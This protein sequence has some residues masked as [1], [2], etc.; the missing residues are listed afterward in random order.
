MYIYNLESEQLQKVLAKYKYRNFNSISWSKDSKRLMFDSR[1][2]F[3]IAS[4]EFI[5]IAADSYTPFIKR[6]YNNNTYIVEMKN[7][8]YDNIV[9]LYNFDNR[10]Y[11]Q[12]ADGLYMDS[13]NT[14]I[15]YTLDYSQG[16]KIVN[17]KTLESKEIENGPI[18]C[19]NILKSTG[20]IVYT[21]TNPYFKD[22][23][24][25]LLVIINPDAMTKKV[26]PLYT[27][28]YYLSP[29]EDKIYFTSNYL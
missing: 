1:M 26:Q 20:E 4:K 13:D 28:T 9:A 18:Y 15:L 27:P 8:K 29:A 10:S 5:S 12:V 19:A 17:L 24:R 23:D 2:V 3:D 7:D 14:N 21:T 11:T 22:D 16:L 25:Y 6:H